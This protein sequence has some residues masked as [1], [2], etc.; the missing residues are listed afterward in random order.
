MNLTEE[1]ATVTKDTN[2]ELTIQYSEM[3]KDPAMFQ[4]FLDFQKW[5]ASTKQ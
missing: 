4:E 2:A 1:A 5:K 3:S